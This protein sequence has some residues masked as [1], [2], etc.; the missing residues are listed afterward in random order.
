MSESI[1]QDPK[2]W[3]WRT[4]ILK[5]GPKNHT[6]R[7]VLLVLSCYMD[8]SGGSCF[9]SYD[10]LQEAT[11]VGRATLSKYLQKA[12]EDGWIKVTQKGVEGQA[13]KRNEYQATVPDVVWKAVHELN[14][15]KGKGSS[16]HDEGSSPHEK[17]VVHEVNSISS[18]VTSSGNSTREPA[19]T[20]EDREQPSLDDVKQYASMNA[21]PP[22][23]AQKFFY[24]YAAEDWTVNG[25]PLVRWK[26][27][28][29]QWKIREHGFNSNGTTPA[30]RGTMKQL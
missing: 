19:H 11:Q 3:D 18:G 12:R 14:H 4:Y 10:T 1:Q 17:K 8:S 9:P 20:R 2:V 26:Q 16:P 22:D 21:I 23:L 30:P 7:H 27:K 5:H 24:H 13:W 29:K 6:Y 28:L 25:R 15:V